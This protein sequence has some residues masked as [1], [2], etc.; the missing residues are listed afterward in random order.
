MDLI[1]YL[2][3]SILCLSSTIADIFSFPYE[4]N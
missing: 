3:F 1:F 2:V 4:L